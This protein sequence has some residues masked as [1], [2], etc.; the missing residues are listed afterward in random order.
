MLGVIAT[1]AGRPLLKAAAGLA[2]QPSKI[3][4]FGCAQN[5]I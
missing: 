3:E 1:Q 5:Y 4:S 2:G